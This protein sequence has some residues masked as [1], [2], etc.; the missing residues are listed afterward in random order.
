VCLW[1]IWQSI[2]IISGTLET[3]FPWMGC[4]AAPAV[5]ALSSRTKTKPNQTKGVAWKWENYTFSFLD[6]LASLET[7]QVGGSIIVSNLSQ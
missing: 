6:A 3:Y 4:A 7:T 1:Q 2:H 5:S